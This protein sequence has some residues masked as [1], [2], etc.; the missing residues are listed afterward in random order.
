MQKLLK[1]FNKKWMINEEHLRHCML[2]EYKKSTSA[3]QATRNIC[4]AYDKVLNV[5]TCQRWFIK[6]SSGNFD[7]KDSP[8]SGRP[9]SIDQEALKGAVEANSKSTSRELVQMFN[10]T[11][12]SIISSLRRLGKVS[13]LGQ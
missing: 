11:H 2:Y 8:R 3:A 5:R 1:T 7:I 4:S 12:T 9:K 10:I 13:K 6:F